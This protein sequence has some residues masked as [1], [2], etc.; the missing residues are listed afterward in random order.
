MVLDNF[1][2]NNFQNE[3]I[4]KLTGPSVSGLIKF[5]QT[6][7]G[8]TVKGEIKGLSKGKHGFHV[9][10][11]GDLTDGC[12]STA[13]HFNPYN[14][15]FVFRFRQKLLIDSF[16]KKHGAPTAAERHVG[17]LGNIEAN[18]LGVANV[19]IFDSLISLTGTD[20]IVGRAVVV[21]SDEDDLG[22]GGH[23]DS[24]TTGH[25]GSRVAC[26]VIGIL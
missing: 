1:L 17:D 7:K 23:E 6:E 20:C 24:T 9:H 5:T 16:Q 15:S 3:A 19:D 2:A 10:Q 12:T 8:V 25:A 26:G 21:H 11:K 18:E 14:V 4:V 13:G 22:L